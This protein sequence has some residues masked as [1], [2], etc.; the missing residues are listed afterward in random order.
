MPQNN[1]EDLQVNPE[2]TEPKFD[3]ILPIPVET[4]NL[5]ELISDDILEDIL[6]KKR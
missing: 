3:L 2:L 1:Y 5:N 6:S 4:V